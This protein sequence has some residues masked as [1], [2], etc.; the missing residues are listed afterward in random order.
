MVGGK[1]L[2]LWD[3]GRFVETIISEVKELIH[4]QLFFGFDTFDINWSPGVVHEEPRNR[5]IGYSCF[6]DPSNSFARHKF[7]VLR[8]ILTHPSTLSFCFQGR[9]D[10]VE[11]WPMLRVHGCLP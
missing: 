8:V 9:E 3:I 11:G 6:G 5:T 7:D 10:C 2:H 4:G 1:V